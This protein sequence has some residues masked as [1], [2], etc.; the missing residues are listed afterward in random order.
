MQSA[1]TIWLHTSSFACVYSPEPSGTCYIIT[2]R[3]KFIIYLSNSNRRRPR[4]TPSHHIVP[5]S[6]NFNFELL[7]FTNFLKD[8]Y[9]T[10][11]GDDEEIC[12]HNWKRSGRILMGRWRHVQ[13]SNCIAEKKTLTTDILPCFMSTVFTTLS[14]GVDF[15]NPKY[16]STKAHVIDQPV[17]WLQPPNATLCIMK[18]CKWGSEC[19]A[20]MLKPSIDIIQHLPRPR[21]TLKFYKGNCSPG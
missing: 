12:V 5:I 16:Y 2:V 7:V 20:T 3:W 6:K 15:L 18:V 8:N 10:L 4:R 11:S 21:P 17:Q 13:H 9:G 14:Y 1:V 19:V